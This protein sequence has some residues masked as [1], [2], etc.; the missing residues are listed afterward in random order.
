MS[1][2]TFSSTIR[3][4][5][6]VREPL[7]DVTNTQKLKRGRTCSQNNQ[8]STWLFGKKFHLEGWVPETDLLKEVNISMVQQS[9]LSARKILERMLGANKIPFLRVS[10]G[11]AKP[12]AP[13]S[14]LPIKGYY[15][16]GNLESPIIK[17]RISF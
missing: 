11:Q 6:C 8:T 3:Q 15:Y 10:K 5:K 2:F 12:S 7:G 4:S 9:F 14:K 1:S 17:E 16:L 13:F